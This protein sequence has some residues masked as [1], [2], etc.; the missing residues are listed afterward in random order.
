[1]VRNR[2]SVEWRSDR[3]CLGDAICGGAERPPTR[4]Q[5]WTTKGAAV[6]G[7]EE[8]GL[9]PGCHLAKSA[10]P[11]LILASDRPPPYGI[12]SC[13]RGARREGTVRQR[14]L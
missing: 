5:Q 8:Q 3:G 11:F 6:A 10:T 12:V 7:S 9:I 4:T 1:M 14:L 13:E 2:S